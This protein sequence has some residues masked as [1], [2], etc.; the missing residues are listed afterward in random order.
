MELFEKNARQAI[1][2]RDY[3]K[4]Q[5]VAM[6]RTRRSKEKIKNYLSK[7]LSTMLLATTLMIPT[8]VQDF[9]NPKN[10]LK[11]LE[12]QPRIEMDASRININHPKM[13][14]SIETSNELKPM[15]KIETKKI[16]LESAQD[17]INDVLMTRNF[18]R[19][20]RM[21]RSI[22]HE[23][24]IPPLLVHSMIQTES[25]YNPKARSSAM[26]FGLMGLQDETIKDMINKGIIKPLPLSDYRTN[27]VLNIK[28]GLAYLNWLKENLY[29]DTPERARAFREQRNFFERQPQWWKLKQ[30]LKAYNVGIN[31]FYKKGYEPSKNSYYIMTIRNME[32]ISGI[33]KKLAIQKKRSETARN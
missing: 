6:G 28:A 2:D 32:K 29:R 4:N 1:K 5:V 9:Q 21:V 23:Y 17:K 15:K 8:K 24:N 19:Y 10:P 33:V 27:P 13:V 14:A 26:A 16:G 31:N 22:A 12:N 7:T 20:R 30:A 18:L 11:I 25:S 3:F